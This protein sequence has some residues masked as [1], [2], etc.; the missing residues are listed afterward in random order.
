MRD[1]PLPVTANVQRP[2][3]DLETEAAA[4]ALA[5]ATAGR[6]RQ[7][8]HSPAL[9][10]S[11][12]LSS[13]LGV[14]AAGLLRK[15]SGRPPGRRRRPP[16]DVGCFS[17][18]QA[19]SRSH[20]V[21]SHHHR[22][23]AP[24]HAPAVASGR[25][26]CEPLLPQQTD[27]SAQPSRHGQD[28]IRIKIQ[29]HSLPQRAASSGSHRGPWAP[30]PRVGPLPRTGAA[31]G[32]AR[33]AGRSAAIGAGAS[34]REGSSRASPQRRI[35]RVVIAV[36]LLRTP[37]PAPPGGGLARSPTAARA[38]PP[39]RRAG[40]VQALP[41]AGSRREWARPAVLPRTVPH[42]PRCRHG[43]ARS[44]RR[45]PVCVTPQAGSRAD[46]PVR[47]AQPRRGVDLSSCGHVRGLGPAPRT[48][49]PPPA[50]PPARSRARPVSRDGGLFS[51]DRIQRC[52][53]APPSARQRMRGEGSLS[54]P[55]S[56]GR[57][58]GSPPAAAANEASASAVGPKS[59]P[60]AGAPL[61]EKK[62]GALPKTSDNRLGDL[63]PQNGR[64]F[65]GRFRV[66]PPS[67]L[68]RLPRRS[69]AQRRHR[70]GGHAHRDRDSASAARVEL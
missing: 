29:I 7:G 47:A 16:K 53:R 23:R 69:A 27:I 6:G 9:A 15:K 51:R 19:V 50:R 13:R 32:I 35:V 46:S 28:R 8:G 61:G 4:G 59:P 24:A 40:V 14:T 64:P 1:Q 52:F 58:R 66:G 48:R 62:R 44:A 30:P 41:R 36:R 25:L 65:T 2:R 70:R 63:S 20:A 43:Q 37:R 33:R 5:A 21:G 67:S 12:Q 42:L 57:R 60:P 10:P 3:K 39:P 31:A 18:R 22:D 56:R 49:L 54:R 17:P 26:Q 55:P 45:G 38:D 11:Q 68:R 34:P